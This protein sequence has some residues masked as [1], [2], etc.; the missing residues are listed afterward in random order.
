MYLQLTYD[1][2]EQSRRR[3]EPYPLAYVPFETYEGNIPAVLERC[4]ALGLYLELPVAEW[5]G[6]ATKKELPISRAARTTLGRNI[7][8][9]AVHYKG[10][11]YADMTYRVPVMTLHEAEQIGSIWENHPSHPLEKACLAE[12]GVFLASLSIMRLFGGQSL[13]NLAGEVSRDEQRHVATNRGILLDLNINP[14]NPEPSLKA[15]QEDTLSWLTQ[16]L[17]VSDMGI[18]SDF[19]ASQSDQLITQGH[20]PELD[21]LTDHSNYVPPFERANVRLY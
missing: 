19:F 18:D 15:L 1:Q 7:A 12:T 2:L 20:A 17:I 16:G 5:V 6:E 11:K 8:D 9:E 14:A 4:I 3:W 21:E 10:F 13:A